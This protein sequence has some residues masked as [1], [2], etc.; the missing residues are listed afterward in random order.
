MKAKS[1]LFPILKV[2][3]RD[4]YNQQRDFNAKTITLLTELSD[5]VEKLKNGAQE[6]I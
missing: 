3:L 6:R 1:C 2:L 4:S 5:E